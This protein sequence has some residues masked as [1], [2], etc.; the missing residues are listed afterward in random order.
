MLAIGA[1]GSSFYDVQRDF[2]LSPGDSADIG[3]YEFLYLNIKETNYG[4]RTEQSAK[5]QVYK[6]ENNLGEMVA[7]RTYYPSHNIAAT[8]AAIKSN[9]IEDFYIVPSE[10]GEG[11]KAVFRVY[12]NPLVWWMWLAGPVMMLGAFI[13]ISHKI[14]YSQDTGNLESVEHG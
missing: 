14:S 4:D 13:A 3:N 11:G 2:V 1:L 9:P 12:V 7:K 10:F 8:R 6:K 5:F